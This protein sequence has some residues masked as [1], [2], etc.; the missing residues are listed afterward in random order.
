MTLV[1]DDPLNP[2]PAFAELYTRLP[3]A[4]DLWPWLDLARG[5]AA[6]VLYLGIGTGRIAVPLHRAGIE[7][8]GVDS[9]PAML[10]RLSERVP[11]MQLVESRI[12]SLQLDRLFDLVMAPSNIL[13][14]V[15]RLRG[16]ARHV[17]PGGVVAIELTN[18]HW[19]RAA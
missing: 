14:L 10:A 7:L 2:D 17:A 4:T 3:D 8:I 18:P 13:Y 1:R 11:S 12:E 5:A 15:E 6:P 16:A 19:L 9:H